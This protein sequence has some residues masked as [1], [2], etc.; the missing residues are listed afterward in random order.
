LD[1]LSRGAGNE[2]I[3]SFFARNRENSFSHEI[4]NLK[5]LA[6]E[7]FTALSIA[8]EVV[9][10]TDARGVLKYQGPSPD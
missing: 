2:Y 7:Y 1:L 10:A 5:E 9:V 6:H 4:N 8:H 3:P